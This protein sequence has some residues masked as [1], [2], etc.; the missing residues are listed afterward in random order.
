MPKW[1]IEGPGGVLLEVDGDSEP[2]EQDIE[3]FFTEQKPASVPSPAPVVV[4]P[5]AWNA[6]TGEVSP[7]V[8]A[9]AP[10]MVKAPK[11]EP[12]SLSPDAVVPP[13]TSA[14]I[15]AGI[16]R[17]T[18]M[19]TVGDLMA[20]PTQRTKPIPDISGTV[21]SGPT[22]TQRM[23]PGPISDE[24]RIKEETWATLSPQ[25]KMLMDLGVFARPAGE[26][27]AGSL[28]GAGTA[29]DAYGA[30]AL[31][32][33]GEFEA[34][35]RLRERTAAQ[36]MA[37]REKH[38][39]VQAG[40]SLERATQA[41][42]PDVMPASAFKVRPLAI[43]GQATGSVVASLLTGPAAIVTGTLAEYND[44][45][46]RELKRQEDAK[47]P[48]DPDKALTKAGIYAGATVP[49]EFGLGL[50]RILRNVKKYFGADAAAR[51]GKDITRGK[52]SVA[53]N[54]L[55]ERA[56]D[57]P[58]G[59]SQEF[60]EA[61]MQDLIV[62]GKPDWASA[63]KEGVM[64]AIGQTIVGGG[65]QATAM[66]SQAV[67]NRVTP[68]VSTPT[69]T[70][71]SSPAAQKSAVE[72][73]SMPADEFITW[74]RSQK[75]FGQLETDAI[76]ST[77]QSEDIDKLK[78]KLAQLESERKDPTTAEEVNAFQNAETH[79]GRIKEWISDWTA[80]EQR[81][82]EGKSSYESGLTESVAPG[83]QTQVDFLT[84][85]EAAFKLGMADK[86]PA[87]IAAATP[88]QINQWKKSGQP[89]VDAQTIIGNRLASGDVEVLSKA[90]MDADSAMLDLFDKVKETQ[91]S[92]TATAAEKE[93]A[94]NEYA[95]NYGPL[96]LKSQ[97]IGEI[98]DS[99]S[100]TRPLG[101]IERLPKDAGTKRAKPKQSS[102]AAGPA[103]DTVRVYH[104]KGGADGSGQGGSHFAENQ[105]YSANFGG[106]Q[107]YVDLP[108]AIADKLKKE[109][110]ARGQP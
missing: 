105:Q 21:E 48:I 31:E 81:I 62:D 52:S 57:A 7:E 106:D 54:F 15:P 8:K 67:Q 61:V 108:R 20:L 73:A 77:I 88:E 23:M 82:A 58:A 84:R 2:N 92:K 32:Q 5:Q 44:S 17:G 40:R 24:E 78:A 56:K 16:P 59:F 30:L 68:T 10:W 41:A 85:E 64:G 91:A 107:S 1:E 35:R 46:E 94:I 22:I 4:R 69:A 76:V 60:T 45:Y 89:F 42:F 37:D 87:E 43:G 101:T 3:G 71:I 29:M 51:F 96:Q 26:I 14:P 47:E 102:E 34:A 70:T 11:V 75:Q 79:I 93:A 63:F 99:Y 36:K 74:M 28:R 9:A 13:V 83:G 98:L 103:K 38:P 49:V 25:D 104:A 72:L 39:L 33:E 100:G 50:G 97:T 6:W 90:K 12:S 86:T 53:F 27:W 66:A 95:K 109:A 19:P 65:I 55:K 110:A 80:K 18:P